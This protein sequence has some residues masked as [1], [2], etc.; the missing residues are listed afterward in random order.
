MRISEF[1]LGYGLKPTNKFQHMDL[2]ELLWVRL[3]VGFRHS[4]PVSLGG[5]EGLPN[6]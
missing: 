3:Q 5:Y 2:V 4:S 1:V 6:C